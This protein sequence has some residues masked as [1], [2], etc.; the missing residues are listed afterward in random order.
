VESV[1]DDLPA[2]A[3]MKFHQRNAK[4]DANEPQIVSDLEK[5]GAKVW[6]LSQPCDLLVRF[7]FR[8]YLLDVSNPD[9][10]NRRRE[11]AQVERFKDWGV[12]EVTCSDEAL[13][14]IGAM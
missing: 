2:N 6:R 12:V 3:L 9:Y 13:R 7:A 14:A 8:L 5:V 11:K 10:P 1:F 4:R